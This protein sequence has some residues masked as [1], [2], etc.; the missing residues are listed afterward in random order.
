[1]SVK[2]EKVE[3]EEVLIADLGNVKLYKVIE[4]EERILENTDES[5]G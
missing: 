1:M 4:N 3:Q 2:I 5:E